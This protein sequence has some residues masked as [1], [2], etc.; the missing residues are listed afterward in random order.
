M[1]N[2]ATDLSAI[3]KKILPQLE[4]Y[5]E[6]SM[7]GS[8]KVLKQELVNVS[9]QLSYCITFKLWN[10]IT[11]K[12]EIEEIDV[13]IKKAFASKAIISATEEVAMELDKIKLAYPPKPLDDYFDKK[14]KAGLAKLRHELANEHHLN[15]FQPLI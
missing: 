12:E 3:I 9:E 1:K 14:M 7:S 8:C 5:I 6:T 11:K 4:S 10:A 2:T 15:C 13:K